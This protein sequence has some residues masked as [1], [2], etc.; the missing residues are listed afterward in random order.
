MTQM[1]ADGHRWLEGEQESVGALEQGREP[2]TSNP[3]RHRDLGH[4]WTLRLR[5]LLGR[6]GRAGSDGSRWRTRPCH[7]GVW[8]RISTD[9]HGW[10]DGGRERNRARPGTEERGR[11][12][13][14]R[15]GARGTR[16]QARRT[17]DIEA[18]ERRVPAV[19]AELD[20]FQ[21]VQ[22]LDEQP[23]KVALVAHDARVRTSSSG[24]RRRDTWSSIILRRASGSLPGLKAL[25][26]GSTAA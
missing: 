6:A 1:G 23:V 20:G 22:G 2:R 3:P 4:G 19:A 13:E 11:G 10:N 9:W 26:R 18:G 12:R 25:S 7:P 15:D 16:S 5:S 21:F 8:P 24:R 14:P 17:T